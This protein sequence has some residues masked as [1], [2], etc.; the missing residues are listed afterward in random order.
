[1]KKRFLAIDFIMVLALI[2]CGNGG[3]LKKENI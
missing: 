1:M 3:N 2:A